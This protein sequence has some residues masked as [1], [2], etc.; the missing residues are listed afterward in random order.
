MT[1]FI[2]SDTHFFHENFL[3]F[4]KEDGTR[5]RA[6]FETVEE[7]NETMVQRWNERVRPPDHVWHLGDVGCKHKDQLAI[8]DRC[9]GHKRIIPGNHDLHSYKVYAKYFEKIMGYR[10]LEQG[11]IIMS[12]IPLH[13]GSIKLQWTNV[14]GHTH[15]NNPADHLGP[16]Y[17]NVCV[18]YTNYAPLSLE[19]VRERIRIQQEAFANQKE[20]PYA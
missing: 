20:S 13:P 17:L 14:H 2:I 1:I 8:L 9:N 4:R 18:E 16:K 3:T 7:M 15:N 11:D 12:H 10:V 19:E 5:L 6:E